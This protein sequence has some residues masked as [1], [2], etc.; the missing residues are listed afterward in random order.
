VLIGADGEHLPLSG[1]GTTTLSMIDLTE[2]SRKAFRQ[3]LALLKLPEFS[4]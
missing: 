3:R 4:H 1:R 2:K